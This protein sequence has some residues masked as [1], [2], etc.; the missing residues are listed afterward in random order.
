MHDHERYR[1]AK[2][3]PQLAPVQPAGFVAVHCDRS[4]IIE[5]L[6]VGFPTWDCLGFSFVFR[7]RA[8][9]LRNGIRLSTAWS[10]AR[11]ACN[12]H[13]DLIDV[14]HS[15]ALVLLDRG[16][17]RLAGDASR[18]VAAD[19]VHVLVQ[20]QRILRHDRTVRVRGD[21]R[22]LS[23]LMAVLH[24]TD[25]IAGIV[26]RGCDRNRGLDSILVCLA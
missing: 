7:R 1:P 8:G 19:G 16:N 24:R 23:P 6:S 21:R 20:A 4:R 17:E 5:H 10:V 25:C 11:L 26:G 18:S 22:I 15:G 2:T 9:D 3:D 14:G 13:V 12:S